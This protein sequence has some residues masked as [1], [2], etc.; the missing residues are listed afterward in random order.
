[1]AM[2]SMMV[3]MFR[4]VALSCSLDTVRYIYTSGNFVPFAFRRYHMMSGE[5]DCVSCVSANSPRIIASC[6]R[7]ADM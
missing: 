3:F 5:T 4:V 6:H 1:M 7:K 2:P